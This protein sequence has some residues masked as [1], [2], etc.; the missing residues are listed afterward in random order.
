MR[1]LASRARIV[2]LTILLLSLIT[3]LTV[4][5]SVPLRQASAAFP[6]SHGR[7]AFTSIRDG[8]D[9]IYS[10]DTGGGNQVNLSNHPA[11]EFFSWSRMRRPL[12]TWLAA[13]MIAPVLI[14][15]ALST[16]GI[17]PST[18]FS[19]LWTGTLSA[20]AIV[21]WSYPRFARQLAVV[22][23]KVVALGITSDRR[24]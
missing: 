5:G 4:A 2:A 15:V 12:P 24:P 16:A 21:W 7:I 17:L 13:L 1:G 3:G 11:D 8:N 22:Q 6:G 18:G 23:Q 9:E 20:V 19:R 10:M 14:D